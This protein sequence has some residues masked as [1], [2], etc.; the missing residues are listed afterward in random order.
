MNFAD[1]LPRDMIASMYHDLQ[2]GKPLELSWL[3]GGGVDIGSEV[4]VPTPVNRA[5]RDVLL[6]HARG[7]ACE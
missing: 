4:G 7:R 6:L 1:G 3:S 5:F 2:Q